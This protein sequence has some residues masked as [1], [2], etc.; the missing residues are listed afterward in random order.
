MNIGIHL[1]MINILLENLLP[2]EGSEI[3]TQKD[4]YNETILNGL[5]LSKGVL[6]SSIK[7]FHNGDFKNYISQI[8]NKYLIYPSF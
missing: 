1:V 5:R 6:T 8:K 3:L 7:P 2:T 4:H